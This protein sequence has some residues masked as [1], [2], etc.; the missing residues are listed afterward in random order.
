MV[1]ENQP[2]A[3]FR[4]L[5]VSFIAVFILVSQAAAQVDLSGT[6]Q[7]RYL[8]TA[9]TAHVDHRGDTLTGFVIVHERCDDTVY[10]FKGT[11]KGNNIEASHHDGHTFTGHLTPDGTI[12]GTLTMKDNVTVQL[13]MTRESQQN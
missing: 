12:A 2:R 13:T 4:K 7:G 8:F 5:L 1:N 11:L 6:W 3:I 10:H 9:I